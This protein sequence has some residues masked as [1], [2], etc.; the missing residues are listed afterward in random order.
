MA[1]V[2]VSVTASPVTGEAGLGLGT[3]APVAVG[4]GEVKCAPRRGSRGA[5]RAHPGAGL[6][7]AELAEAGSGGGRRAGGGSRSKGRRPRRAE[8][9]GGREGGNL[10]GPG[11]GRDRRGTRRTTSPPISGDRDPVIIKT[12]Q[13][14]RKRNRLPFAT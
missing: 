13:E 2:A 10:A 1:E 14:G 12:I 4:A 6:P 3:G 11:R 5:G 9:A 7:L 8:A